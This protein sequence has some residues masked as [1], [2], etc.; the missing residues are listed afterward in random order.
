VLFFGLIRSFKHSQCLY[1]KI[2]FSFIPCEKILIKDTRA[3][4]QQSMLAL[5]PFEAFQE[6]NSMEG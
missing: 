2:I 4:Q 5:Q 6:E 3:D 1:H